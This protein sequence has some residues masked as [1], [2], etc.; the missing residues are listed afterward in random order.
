M[1]TW[2]QIQITKKMCGN[3]S[4]LRS[5]TLVKVGGTYLTKACSCSGWIFMSTTPTSGRFRLK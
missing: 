5:A 3:L 2:I 1:N 4:G